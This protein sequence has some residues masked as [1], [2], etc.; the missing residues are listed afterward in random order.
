MPRH[1]PV[2]L[3]LHALVE[4][5][6]E[7]PE[8]HLRDLARAISAHC[9][10]P[11]IVADQWCDG[12]G[13]AQS[14]AWLVRRLMG[15]S[16]HTPI[17]AQ[18]VGAETRAMEVAI[19]RR[20]ADVG[21]ALLVTQDAED[22][23]AA[24]LLLDA[25]RLVVGLERT[26][27]AGHDDEAA[28]TI[29]ALRYEVKAKAANIDNLMDANFRHQRDI[30]EKDA[31]IE[32]LEDAA[33]GHPFLAKIRTALD[34][35][36]DAPEA[37]IITAAYGVLRAA[38]NGGFQY[39]ERMRDSGLLAEANKHEAAAAAALAKI[40]IAIRLG[41]DAT[42]DAIIARAEAL[43]DDESRRA[44]MARR[45]PH[46]RLTWV[47]RFNNGNGGA[48]ITIDGHTVFVSG[49]MARE[50]S[51]ALYRHQ[52]VLKARTEEC[53]ALREKLTIAQANSA[54]FIRERDKAYG[55]LC[56]LGWDLGDDG[57]WTAPATAN[58]PTFKPGDRVVVARKAESRTCE[59]TTSNGNA[60][61]RTGEVR[62]IDED[63]DVQVAIDDD[64]LWFI[65]A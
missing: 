6:L 51:E 35:N 57:E 3:I 54:T 30:A 37:E 50:L 17:P 33:A 41:S 28:R 64:R 61:G 8:D 48:S 46:E 40:G 24:S 25:S 29:D 12:A 16:H 4:S 9:I 2:D 63:G 59:W 15:A 13:V 38:R 14:A 5:L 32:R 52:H 21:L 26:Q 11:R 49:T 65:P 56:A 10:D 62:H 60:L 55:V 19:A 43:T 45:P 39:V 44:V 7:L 1:I 42:I 47:A 34:L 53:D 20:L 18:H 31:A 27:A 22:R 58:R 36:A 23:S